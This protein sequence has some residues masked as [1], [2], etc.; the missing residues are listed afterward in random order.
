M[1]LVN[2]ESA[3]DSVFY[4]LKV[5]NGS[6][7]SCKKTLFF[8]FNNNKPT[9]WEYFWD[10]ENLNLWPIIR[11]PAYGKLVSQEKEIIKV[12]VVPPKDILNGQY[13]LKLKTCGR[14]GDKNEA[15]TSNKYRDPQ[16]K[17]YWEF[18]SLSS[19]CSTIGL[20]YNKTKN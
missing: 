9:G 20:I 2:T 19:S 6:N 15:P 5:L 16:W 4:T 11:D 18:V 3:S 8:A 7:L 1:T 12:R 13:K 17:D 10:Y 14:F